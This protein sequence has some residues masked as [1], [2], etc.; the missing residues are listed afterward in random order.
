MKKLQH[1]IWCRKK[2]M[3]NYLDFE[4][5]AFDKPL[6]NPV[7]GV[8]KLR[9]PSVDPLS[10]IP[11]GHSYQFVLRLTFTSNQKDIYVL[12]A[13][14]NFTVQTGYSIMNDVI[15]AEIIKESGVYKTEIRIDG[16]E[17]HTEFPW[18]SETLW[19]VTNP[20]P[21]YLKMEFKSL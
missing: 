14:N 5:S 8:I 13:Q 20:S 3:S 4:F 15:K 11:A 12:N 21:T 1:L 10:H 17:F 16:I 2:R 6:T 18:N 19:F 7:E 9:S